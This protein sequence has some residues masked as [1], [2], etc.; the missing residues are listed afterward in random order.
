MGRELFGISDPGSDHSEELAK[1]L[2]PEEA[3][4]L[5]SLKP[6]DTRN[7]DHLRLL[8]GDPEK[9]I[10]YGRG[11]SLTKA[12]FYHKELNW[13]MTGRTLSFIFFGTKPRPN[14]SE[15]IAKKLWPKEAE[16]LLSKGKIDL[17]NDDHLRLLIGDMDYLF[18][19][20]GKV[21]PLL[22][23]PFYCSERNWSMSGGIIGKT[24]FNEENPTEVHTEMLARRLWP[25][26]AEKKIPKEE[27]DLKNDDHLRLLIGGV[28]N[29]IQNGRG[30]S[31]V[32]CRF[33]C[34]EKVWNISG[35]QIGRA[36]FDTEN[37][38]SSHAEALAR[39]LW[40]EEAVRLLGEK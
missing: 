37:S 10:L 14:H 2:W 12:K 4:R 24:L 8:I 9:L 38:N 11:M 34:E 6:L 30:I 23:I 15:E 27:I 22:M 17:K 29:L 28:E 40:P 20:T 13:Y 3:A 25:E 5:L 32:K 21:K 35:G 33:I 18:Y 31:L 36:L 7:H 26:E 1:R 16:E 19:R 39:R